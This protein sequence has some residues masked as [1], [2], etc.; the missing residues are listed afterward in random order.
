MKLELDRRFRKKAFAK[1]VFNGIKTQLLGSSELVK[2]HIKQQEEDKNLEIKIWKDRIS[3][4]NEKY[5]ELNSYGFKNRKEY[6]SSSKELDDDSDMKLINI[7]HDINQL[8]TTDDM[9]TEYANT[10]NKYQE[11]IDAS[12]KALSLIEK[13]SPIASSASIS[14]LEEIDRL[15]SENNCELLLNLPSIINIQQAINDEYNI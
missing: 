14:S 13:I 9:Q 10:Q 2:E 4:L 1:K 3:E 11:E 8:S 7:I 12:R 6:F 5:R 15:F